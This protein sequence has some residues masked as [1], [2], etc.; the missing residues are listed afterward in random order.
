[1]FSSTPYNSEIHLNIDCLE[2]AIQVIGF[3]LFLIDSEAA[4][5]NK[6]DGK[7]KLN[8]HKIDKIFKVAMGIDGYNQYFY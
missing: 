1:M 2:L 4:N 5:I 7:K 8:L 6:L 3:S